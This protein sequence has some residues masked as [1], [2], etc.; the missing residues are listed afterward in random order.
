MIGVRFIRP[1]APHGAGDTRM[2]PSE[3]AALAFVDASDGAAELYEFPT[4]PHAAGS[5]YQP[6]VIKPM[7]PGRGRQGLITK[8][9]GEG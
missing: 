6:P 1:M 4:D 8:L 2:M 5:G 9:F 7:R 3:A